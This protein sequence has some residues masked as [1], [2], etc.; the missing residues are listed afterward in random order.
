M[1][2]KRRSF[3]KEFKADAVKLV[4]AG[5]RSVGQ[6]AKDLDLTETTLRSWVQQAAVDAGS[7]PEGALSTTEKA[8]LAK[9]RQENRVLRMERDLL[10]KAAAFFAKEST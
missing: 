10:K 8:E 2:R 4:K 1:A 9:L 3:T 7:G 6:V 5:G